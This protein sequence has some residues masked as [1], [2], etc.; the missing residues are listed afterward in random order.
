MQSIGSIRVQRGIDT[1]FDE[2]IGVVMKI[3]LAVACSGLMVG[4][5]IGAQTTY[6]YAEIQGHP[7]QLEYYEPNS[8]IGPA[9]LIIWIHGGGWSNGTRF[10]TG[11]SLGFLNQGFAVA[12]LDYRLT[13][14]AGDWGSASVVWPAQ[15]HDIKAAVRWLRANAG[16]LGVD[17]C[18]FISW[19]SSAGGHLSAI[20]GTSNGHPFLEGTLGD[21][22]GVSSDVQLSVDYFGP[23]EPLF[24]NLDV[25]DPPGSTIDHDAVNSPESRLLGSDVHGHSVGDIRAHLGDPSEPWPELRLLALTA[26]PAKLA[27]NPIGS[28]PMFIAHGEED[29]TVPIGQSQ[30]LYDAM[31]T[32]GTPVEFLRVP[33]AG[34]GL[35]NAIADDVLAWLQSRLPL[36][37]CG[38]DADVA[39]PFG[40]LD[41][42]DVLAFIT[43]LD[44]HSTDADIDGDGAFTMFDLLEYLVLYDAG[45]P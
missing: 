41:Q 23:T 31:S 28:V 34:H 25:T 26:S 4:A 39:Q 19:G 3:G 29:T 14:Q 37:A 8:G 38:C 18:S 11:P 12:S 36:P 44:D 30:R 22:V 16:T 35:P 5:P 32:A 2:E 43:L 9:P 21:H 10:N 27:E 17:P 45:C 24:M 20:L 6:T 13:T 42:S 33:D 1:G 15:A 7:L 40:V